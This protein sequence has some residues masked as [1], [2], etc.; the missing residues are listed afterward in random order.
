M[1]GS[2]AACSSTRALSS[3][4][5]FWENGPISARPVDESQA[6]PGPCHRIELIAFVCVDFSL[7]V[8]T[9]G[10]VL[11]PRDFGGSDGEGS[12]FGFQGIL[13]WRREVRLIL[14][15]SLDP[16]VARIWP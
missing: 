2:A 8:P 10:I 14:L 6:S 3:D 16:N 5:P 4:R 12:D 1:A 13:L 11:K 9:K 7:V 15:W